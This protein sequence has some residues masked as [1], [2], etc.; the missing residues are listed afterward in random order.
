MIK[1]CNNKTTSS[2]LLEEYFPIKVQ[3]DKYDLESHKNTIRID[4]DDS[5]ALELLFNKNSTKEIVELNLLVSNNFE[6]INSALII[7]NNISCFS[8]SATKSEKFVVSNFKIKIYNNAAEL[9]FENEEIQHSVLCGDVIFNFSYE[10]KI[11]S[12]ILTNINNEF[13]NHIILELNQNI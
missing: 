7:P 13:Y 11:L 8:I 9:L 10:M 2:Y 6:I 3:F 1:I 12:I 5:N 4:Y